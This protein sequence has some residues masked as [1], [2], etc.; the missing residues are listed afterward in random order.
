M[1]QGAFFAGEFKGKIFASDSSGQVNCE[2]RLVLRRPGA[3]LVEIETETKAIRR[4]LKQAAA[5]FVAEA[6][7][8]RKAEN[9]TKLKAEAERKL[10]ADE[11]ALS[12]AEAERQRL[13]ETVAQLKAEAERRRVE[14][15]VARLRA[16]AER[17]KEVTA[18]AE[19]RTKEQ[20]LWQSVADSQK[21]EDV[22][23]Y[24]DSYPGGAFASRARA[25][26]EQLA[27]TAAQR[28]ELALW[29]W[30]K[31]NRGAAEVRFYL[32]AYP[33]GLFVD[34]A[35]ARIKSLE[36][37]SAQSAALPKQRDEFRL[38]EAVQGSRTP[39]DFKDYLAR[40]PQGRFRK[41]AE[42]RLKVAERLAVIAGIDFGD[43]HALVIGNKSYEHLPSLKTA[44]DD[45]R[46]VA[47]ILRE[48]YGFKVKLMTN[49]PRKDIIDVLDEFVETLRERD[50]L[51]IYYAA[52]TV[53]STKTPDAVTG[54]RW[55]PG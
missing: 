33:D 8:E 53:G 34:I 1:L 29:N 3:E 27:A 11:E 39:Q 13:A 25:R 5:K 23:R 4:R 32:K 55:T 38:W 47:A 6:E 15:E 19:T 52:A 50:N 40:F 26:I 2:A 36:A 42:A 45:A 24:L 49:A 54:C 21:I 41:Q 10:L 37:L 18:A 51:L 31:D 35:E 7:K 14:Q 44:V 48:D 9:A 46:A 43:Y 22:Q 16:E 30:V 28:Q 20:A 17:S 12:K